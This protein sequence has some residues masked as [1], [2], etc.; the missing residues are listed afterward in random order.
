MSPEPQTVF[1][2]HDRKTGA[3]QSAYSR[4]YHDEKDFGSVGSARNAN[5]HGVYKDKRKYRVAKYRVIY[6]LIEGD[7]D[8]PT[9]EETEAL[10]EAEKV[11]K[12]LIDKALRAENAEDLRGTIE[13]EYLSESRLTRLKV[14]LDK[15]PAESMERVMTL[16]GQGIGICDYIRW[17]RGLTKAVREFNEKPFGNPANP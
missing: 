9:P 17:S 10:L 13:C 11:M 12:E 8:A 5:V 15:H 6:E 16:I 4:A 2:I 3:V 7:C 1:R 14:W